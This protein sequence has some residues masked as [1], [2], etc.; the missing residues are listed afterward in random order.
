M[1]SI[2]V[3]VACVAVSLS[4]SVV[5]A[6]VDVASATMPVTPP[7]GSLTSVACSSS[8]SCLAV[9]ESTS[10]D[11]EQRALAESWDGT[12]WSLTEPPVPVGAAADFFTS[13]ACAPRGPCFA[14]GS[15]I[16][17]SNSTLVDSLVERFS[18]G[19]WTIQGTPRASVHNYLFGIA[20][21]A[22]RMCVAVGK[23]V[24]SGAM[25]EM[26]NGRGWRRV[27]PPA[28]DISGFTSVACGSTDACVA[29]GFVNSGQVLIE[30]WNGRRWSFS[31]PPIP[32]AFNDL[33]GAACSSPVACF[34]VGD[35]SSPDF[36]YPLVERLTGT[37]R[38]L[39]PVPTRASWD[40]SQLT[41]VACTTDRACVTVGSSY[42][43]ATVMPLVERWNGS[44]WALQAAA[45]G[46]APG[47]SPCALANGCLTGGSLIGVSCP[48]AHMCTAVGEYADGSGA[49]RPLAERWDGHVWAS[50]LTVNP[51]A[52]VNA[53]LS[54]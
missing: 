10:S 17:P 33:P 6:T 44:R 31:H 13:V 30:R 48:A 1:R 21:P 15:A 38:S 54:K 43:G 2:G 3:L 52:S 32:D 27:R 9:G 47:S 34:V 12:A 18:G 8:R 53:Q 7:T 25:T 24:F 20:C 26:W 29:A 23:N 40:A 42:R 45:R 46:G 11:G 14:V 28:L 4:L 51:F 41:A 36:E 5:T 39:M 37:K 50:Q 19:R 16:P 49:A 22:A 35:A